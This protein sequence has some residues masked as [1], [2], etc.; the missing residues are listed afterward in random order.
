[1][2]KAVL[3]DLDN[4]LIDFMKMKR[5]ASEAAVTGMM[6]A[7]LKMNKK[8]A[9]EILYKLYFKH[10]IENQ[11]I[12]N[13]FLR[14]TTGSVDIRLLAAAVVAY[15]KGKGGMLQPYTSVVPT[16]KKL[17]AK[18]KLAIVTDAPKF[19]AWTRLYEL[20]IDKFFNFVLTPE[21]TGSTKPSGIPF[22]IAIDKLKM[23]PSEIAVVGDWI[24]RDIIPAKS[25]GL[26]TILA[27]YGQVWKEVG[28]ADYEIKS[29][30]DI[31][32][33]LK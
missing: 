26:R 30:T 16:L 23:K 21:D 2:I 33:C 7:G 11:N 10:G 18:Y 4:T 29:F 31:M 6:D 15:R 28:K 5:K 25:L 9:L 1:M 22:R 13:E 14:E 3:M 8:K 27:K 24:S 12:F 32:E 19:Q 17:K 20:G